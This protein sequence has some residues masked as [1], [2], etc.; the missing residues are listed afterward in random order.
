MRLEQSLDRTFCK[1]TNSKTFWRF[2][3]GFEPQAPSGYASG[4]KY[5]H[6]VVGSWRRSAAE[7][8]AGGDVERS[9]TGETVSGAGVCWNE[10]RRRTA[11]TAVTPPRFRLPAA[12][13][14]AAGSTGV[15][16]E[17]VIVIT[18][19]AI[20][21]VLLVTRHRRPC[22]TSTYCSLRLW[23]RDDT[24]SRVN[25]LKE[26]LWCLVLSKTGKKIAT[27]SLWTLFADENFRVTPEGG[28]I[29]WCPSP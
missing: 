23:R 14:S 27:L 7:A 4:E 21:T 3:W 13:G 22:S 11:S 18:T 8:P 20:V 12:E 9:G 10:R 19:V 24:V 17:D 15:E 16:G 6:L 25:L 1:H 29:T 28:G 5:M 26:L 2:N